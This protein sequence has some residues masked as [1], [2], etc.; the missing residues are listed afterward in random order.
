MRKAITLR[1]YTTFDIER[2]ADDG[3]AI[4]TISDADGNTDN[5]IGLHLEFSEVEQAIFDGTTDL[6]SYTVA[7][8]DAYA[9]AMNVTD[10]PEDALKAVKLAFL[11]GE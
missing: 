1:E 6:D 4:G 7:E 11:K 9:Y 10:Y 8:L 5:N 3:M 2:F